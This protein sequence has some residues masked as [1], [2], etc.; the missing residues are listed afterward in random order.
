MSFQLNPL[1]RGVGRDRLNIRAGKTCVFCG[2][3][4][5]RNNLKPKT[6]S[7]KKQTLV[8]TLGN[9]QQSS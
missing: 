3:A 5:V 2:I 6:C 7:K 4:T 1:T 8:P 9:K